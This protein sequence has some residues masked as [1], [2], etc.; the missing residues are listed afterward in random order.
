MKLSVWPNDNSICHVNKVTYHREHL[1]LKWLTVI[2]ILI[3][4]VA[5][6]KLSLTT[7]ITTFV[8]AALAVSFSPWKLSVL[9]ISSFEVVIFLGCSL[10]SFSLPCAVDVL[11]TG[12]YS[13]LPS[14]I[15]VCTVLVMS[16][17]CEYLK[18]WKKI[19]RIC[20][21]WLRKVRYAC[22][23]SLLHENRSIR[24]IVIGFYWSMLWILKLNQLLLLNLVVLALVECCV[25]LI[26]WLL[27]IGDVV[28]HWVESCTWYQ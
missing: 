23:S 13:R 18:I 15:R 7:R 24:I 2:S 19:N 9:L 20:F 16:E 3:H 8:P 22:V 27:V 12:T 6:P 10:P 26:A 11:T 14:C 17:M 1:V 5:A 25:I 21:Y 4:Q 28:V